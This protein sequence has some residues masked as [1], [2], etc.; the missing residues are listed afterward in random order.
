MFDKLA[1]TQTR[2]AEPAGFFFAPDD[3]TAYVNIQ[4][5]NDDN[6]PPLDDYGTD[7]D[8]HHRPSDHCAEQNKKAQNI[9]HANQAGSIVSS[10]L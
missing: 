4:H 6:M 9:K 8:Q 1:N 3:K 7:P 2:V 5:L 10:P